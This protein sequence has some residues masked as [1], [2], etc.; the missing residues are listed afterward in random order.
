MLHVISLSGI[1]L[2]LHWSFSLLIVAMV[3]MGGYQFGLPGMLAGAFASVGLSISVVLHE[4]GHALAARRFGI[5]TAHITLYPFGGVA[6]IERMPEEPDQEIVIALAGPAVNFVLAAIAGWIWLGTSQPFALVFVA[7]NVLMGLFNLIPAFPMDGGRVLR[8]VLAKYMGFIP[9]SRLA[10]R[11]GRGFAWVFLI[12]AFP[13]RSLNLALVG[14]FLHVAL[15]SEKERLVAMN[16]ERTTG[17][18]PPWEEKPQTFP[19][20]VA[21]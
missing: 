18:P 8:A 2:R 13:L 1:P 3:A 21:R 12:A 14:A 16:W 4:L 9:A 7:S 17:R 20:V 10:V 15:N 11:I 19:G 5:E 6:A